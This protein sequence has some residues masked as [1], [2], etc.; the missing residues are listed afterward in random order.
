[1]T[2]YDYFCRS[3]MIASADAIDVT[4]VYEALA[5]RRAA[6]RSY[7]WLHVPERASAVT[8]DALYAVIAEAKRHGI[9]VISGSDPSN[10]DTWE[11]HVEASRVEPDPQTLNEFITVQL[12]AGSKD[13]LL[14]WMR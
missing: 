5:H 10:Y 14:K 4:A 11:E 12:S 1:M 3:A 7:V 13:E 9:G 6:T 2:S 8:K